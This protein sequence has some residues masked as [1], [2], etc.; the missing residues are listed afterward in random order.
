MMRRQ[1]IFSASN[2]EKAIA[3]AGKIRGAVPHMPVTHIAILAMPIQKTG[4][5]AGCLGD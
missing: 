1:D 2:S 5:A 4:L 3:D